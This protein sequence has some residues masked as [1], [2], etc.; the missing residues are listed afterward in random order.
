ME[1]LR[2]SPWAAQPVLDA[3]A[4]VRALLSRLTLIEEEL[5]NATHLSIAGLI[6]G[7]AIPS[8]ARAGVPECNGIRIEAE[9]QCELQ[10]AGSC[11]ANC[12]IDVYRKACATRLYQVCHEE[13]EVPPRRE[14][15][16]DCGAF[17][18]SQCALGLDVTCHHNC[19]PECVETCEDTCADSD[20]PER[21]KASCAATCDGECTAQC[22]ELPE[23]TSCV[24]HCEECCT[25]SCRAIAGMGCQVQC[26]DQEFEVCE[27]AI[28]ADCDASCE[29]SGALFCDGQF[30]AS[31]DALLQC[32]RSLASVDI[33][34]TGFDV[35]L[36]AEATAS[37]DDNL[38]QLGIDLDAESEGEGAG[39][40][41]VG[42]ATSGRHDAPLGWFVVTLGLLTLTRRRSGHRSG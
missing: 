5:V 39:Q 8:I 6:A 24:Q 9:A 13:C 20:E 15:V 3:L 19:Y 37:I 18:G 27:T 21:C 2:P 42:C 28:D 17:C 34:V 35:E 26:Q 32:A 36:D 11:E 23:D 14:C 4:T 1:T 12:S 10:V 38:A 33:E 30:I 29:G 16:D 40:A 41:G 25:G 7:L 22:G 31:G